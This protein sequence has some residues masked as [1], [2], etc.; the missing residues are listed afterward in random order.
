MIYSHF[1]Q[2]ERLTDFWDSCIRMR[3]KSNRIASPHA[4]IF[5][6]IQWQ[7]DPVLRVRSHSELRELIGAQILPAGI[8]I[9]GNER[10]ITDR[11]NDVNE[12]HPLRT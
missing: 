11:R 9:V 2:F 7:D 3:R 6:P 12:Q 4:I 5:L 10:T 8:Q 1:T